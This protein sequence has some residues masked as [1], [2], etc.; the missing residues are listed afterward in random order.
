MTRNLLLGTSGMKVE[1]KV[2]IGTCDVCSDTVF[3][4]EE[5]TDFGWGTK[6]LCLMHIACCPH[7]RCNGNYEDV[8]C[9]DCGADYNNG[10]L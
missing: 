5:Y 2:I 7:T 4:T 3:S 10:R 6:E 8:W 9:M 1:T